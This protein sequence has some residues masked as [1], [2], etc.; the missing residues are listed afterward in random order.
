[1][2]ILS[3]WP[4]KE[5]TPRSIQVR[6]LEWLE[7]QTA[8]YVILQLPVGSGKSLIGITFSRFVDGNFGNS[9]VLT[10]QRILQKQYED[11][12]EHNPNTNL[13]SLYGK[14]NYHCYSKNTN[15][16]TGDLI[17][18]KCNNC[19]HK[20][21]KTKAIN[22]SNVVLNYDLALLQFNKV[23]DFPKRKLMVCD[24][25][26]GLESLLTEF[27]AIHISKTRL[28]QVKVKWKLLTTLDEAYEWTKDTYL[29]ALEQVVEL[30]ESEIQPLLQ[31]TKLIPED[32]ER[33]KEYDDLQAH[34]A[35][36]T[37]IKFLTLAELK[38]D[39]VLVHDKMNIKFKRLR[40]SQIFHKYI[41]RHADRVLL[42][43][44]TI[45]NYQAFCRDLG[46][47]VEEAAFL[48]LD[49]E[50][51]AE[52][53][54]VI[55]IPHMKMNAEWESQANTLARKEMI[56]G[57]KTVC[58]IHKTEN[59]IIHTTSFG[60]SEWLV[61]NLEGKIPQRIY[62]HNPDSGDDRNAVIKAFSNATK[63]S[64]LISPS[65]TEGL[66]LKYDLARFGIVAKIPYP[67]LGDQ[68]VKAR[69]DLSNEW[70]RRQA[71]IQILQA[72]G[73]I[74]RAIDDKG[75][76]YIL[77]GSWGYLFKQ[78]AHTIPDWWIEGYTEME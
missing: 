32:I 15:C 19:T 73:R 63:P 18:P 76:T 65:I 26:H 24:E 69:M 72:C 4:D 29:P 23:G 40:A 30:M 42:M 78:T 61:T 52:N 74:V 13:A 46:I 8:K 3:Y 21:A 25:A 33:I 48:S 77:D 5:K 27:D 12:F 35:S 20:Q 6:A 47:P 31:Q 7:Q 22:S 75:V 14:A 51:P 58:D 67:Y 56:Q 39:W 49:S 10:P 64:V 68:W 41:G 45:P 53:R 43:S 60:V 38:K 36:V 1:M 71:I 55:Y 59:G 50:F 28:Q 2:S 11:D 9:F 62:H 34:L 70:Y 37:E 16:N 44:A 66:D 57:I 54:P 17:K